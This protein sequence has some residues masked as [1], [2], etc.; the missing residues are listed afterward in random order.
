M[1][2]F[3]QFWV[4]KPIMALASILLQKDSILIDSRVSSYVVHLT[5]LNIYIHYSTVLEYRQTAPTCAN[6]ESLAG[7]M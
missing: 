6:H 2:S 3:D 4:S 7:N 5:D 1:I